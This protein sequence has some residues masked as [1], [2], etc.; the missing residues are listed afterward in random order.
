MFKEY[1]GKLKGI[2]GEERTSTI[3]SKSIIFVVQGSNDI[4]TTYFVLREGHEDFAI[5]AD[6][7]VTFASSFLK[8][9]SNFDFDFSRYSMSVTIDSHD[10]QNKFKRSCMHWGCGE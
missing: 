3:L 5:Y 6:S 1:I 7:L 9:V 10:I 4:T 2:V 8:V